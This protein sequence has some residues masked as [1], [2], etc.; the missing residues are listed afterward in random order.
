QTGG[1]WSGLNLNTGQW[2]TFAP[3]R[4]GQARLSADG[5]T[6]AFGDWPKPNSD[7]AVLRIVEGTSDRTIQNP[8]GGEV[9]QPFFFPDKRNVIVAVCA[10]CDNGPER[11][12]LV[13]MPLN[14]DPPRI[15]SEKEGRIMDW[16]YIAFPRDGRS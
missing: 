9:S 14:G 13:L 15:L 5:K 6:L 8:F 12:S 3:R 1:E 16:E 2:K 10:T 7:D 11:R 4:A